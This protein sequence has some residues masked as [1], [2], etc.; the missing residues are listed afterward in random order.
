LLKYSDNDLLNIQNLGKNCLNEIRKKLNDNVNLISNCNNNLQITGTTIISNDLRKAIENLLDNS[1]PPSTSPL[2]EHELN[3]LELVKQ[4][5]NEVGKEICLYAYFEPHKLTS[6]VNM[7]SDFIRVTKSLESKV[8]ILNCSYNQLDKNILNCKMDS[9]IAAFTADNASIRLLRKNIGNCEHI[10]QLKKYFYKI[11]QD[12]NAF[13][14]TET[15]LNFLKEDLSDIIAYIFKNI[16]TDDK[17]QQIIESRAAGVTLESAGQLFGIT[18][19]RVRQIEKKTQNSFNMYNEK[20]R[21]IPRIYALR[22]GDAV[23]TK[24]E[25]LEILPYKSKELLYLLQNAQTNQHTY[26]KTLDLFIVGQDV[27]NKSIDNH[28]NLIPEIL[29]SAEMDKI[30]ENIAGTEKIHTELIKSAVNKKYKYTGKLYHKPNIALS[31]IYTY[32]LEK[33]YPH[34]IKLFDDKAL[35]ILK[36]SIYENFGKIN[37]PENNRS[38]NARIADISVLCDRGM[39]IHKKYIT[40]STKL[41]DEINNFIQN[42]ERS[43]LTYLELF[44]KFKDNLL[45]NSNVHN[46]YYLQGVLKLHFESNYYF[47][48]DSISKNKNL[49]IEDEI[50]SFVHERREISKEE[51]RAEFNGITEGMLLQTL[52]RC[53]DIILIDNALY[54]SA[55]CL[56]ISEKDYLME[57]FIENNISDIPISAKKLYKN[58]RSQ[59]YDF[60]VRNNITTYEKLFGVLKYMFSDKFKFSRPFIGH[61]DNEKLSK[62]NLIKNYISKSAIVN[63]NDIIRFCKEEQLRIHSLAYMFRQLGNEFI[64]INENEI[65]TIQTLNIDDEKLNK[66]KDMLIEELSVKGYLTIQNIDTFLY[67]PYIGIEWNGFL[68]KS[69]IQQFIDDILIIDIPSTNIYAQTGIVISSEYKNYNYESFIHLILKAEHSKEPFNNLNEIERW[70]SDGGLINNKIPKK[71]LDKLY[72]YKNTDGF[73]ESI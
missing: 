46:R 34:G 13:I 10:Y 38:I 39:Y 71:L 1:S 43:T 62:I 65:A 28:V 54:M 49:K 18:R 4:A 33:F 48:K 68:L 11:T 12:E 44:E 58:M 64:R 31:E 36:N 56:N 63:I 35:T 51:L 5:I 8:D 2:K 26:D 7:F 42:S 45:L 21:I 66:I 57:K 53:N 30:I 67:Y 27:L 41:L 50:E 22:N 20:C 25:L 47:T 29:S 52:A 3:I 70:L 14:L 72:L 60:L 9:F 59:Y 17:I 32:T 19:E 69:I 73:I 55:E 23:I 6:L 61:I 24:K 40:I 16:Y 37:L 15:F